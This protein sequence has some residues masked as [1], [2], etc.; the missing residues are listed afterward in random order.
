MDIRPLSKN[1]EKEI[2]KLQAKKYRNE[3]QLFLAEGINALTEARRGTFYPLRE[4]ILSEETVEKRDKKIFEPPFPHGLPV[5]S[6]SRR[7]M[8]TLST[9][10]SP[11]GV[12]LVCSVSPLTFADL[13]DHPSNTL[14]YCDGIS[15]PGNLGTLF[16][17][18]RWF[19][20]RQFLLSPSCVDP[21][22]T[23]AIRASAGTVF[24]IEIYRPVTGEEL[25]TFARN[26][27]Y[28]ITATTPHEGTPID[29]WSRQK[30]EIILLGQEARGLSQDF[31]EGAQHL[32]SI[33]G[34]GTV[35]SL[36]LAAAASI[37]FY[38]LFQS[39]QV[40]KDMPS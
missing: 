24:G 10:E 39:E 8:E 29:K 14:I 27:G 30:R 37:I 34:S 5:Y 17:T 28:S 36:N 25:R 3:K 31:I 32:L 2:R 22:N 15:D 11:Q 6:C 21:F 18:A 20:F 16:R 19:G 9:E 38:E 13:A 40:Q 26:R 7:A 12:L 35:E 1:H 23:K 33:P 4:I